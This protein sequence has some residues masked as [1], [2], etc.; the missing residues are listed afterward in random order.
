M[1]IEQYDNSKHRGQIIRLWKD[2]FGYR[3]QRNNPEIVIDKKLEIDN[4][5]FVAVYNDAVIGSVIAGYDG[6]RGWIYSLAVSGNYRELGIGTRLLQ[7]AED[8]LK[9]KGCMKI[10]LQILRD[11]SAVKE[12]YEKNG[13]SREERISMGKQITEN[14]PAE[15]GDT[16]Q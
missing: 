14:I 13:Y 8:S 9:E 15:A 16:K 12:F 7:K 5:I 4:L 2:T 10:N 3:E 1:I 11:N 6:H